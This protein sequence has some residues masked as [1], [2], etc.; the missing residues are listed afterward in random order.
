MHLIREIECFFYN[1]INVGILDFRL[2]V[3]FL[4]KPGTE[5]HARS[6][7]INPFFSLITIYLK[8]KLFKR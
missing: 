3:L 6:T 8:L 5:N 1:S 2:S 4:I 7:K